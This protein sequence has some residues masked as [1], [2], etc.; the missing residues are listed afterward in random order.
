MEATVPFNLPELWQTSSQEVNQLRLKILAAAQKASVKAILSMKNF[1]TKLL[2]KQATIAETLLSQEWISVQE[3][4]AP[5]VQHAGLLVHFIRTHTEAFARAVIK[6]HSLKEF[7]F[8]VNAV[9]P[10]M[11]AWFHCDESLSPAALFYTIVLANA[12]PK[13]A[14]RIISPFFQALPTFR[15]IEAVME[16]FTVRLGSEVVLDSDTK[17]TARLRECARA[18]IQLIAD[19]IALLPRAHL[20]LLNLM[21]T[22]AWA[23]KQIKNAFLKYFFVPLARQWVSASP[24]SDYLRLFDSILNV[25]FAEDGFEAIYGRFTYSPLF[26][27]PSLYRCFDQ[28]FVLHLVTAAEAIMAVDLLRTQMEIPYSLETTAYLK[29]PASFRFSPFLVKAFPPEVQVPMVRPIR[30]IYRDIQIQDPPSNTEFERIYRLID[31]CRSSGTVYSTLSESRFQSAREIPGFETFALLKSTSDLFDKCRKFENFLGYRVQMRRVQNWCRLSDRSATIAFLTTPSKGALYMLAP[32]SLRRSRF[33]LCHDPT[34]QAVRERYDQPLKRLEFFWGR[35]EN[36][37]R[38]VCSL[39]QT[40]LP[41]AKQRLFWHA[42]EELHCLAN[43]RLYQQFEILA[44]VLAKVRLLGESM[45]LVIDVAVL[46]Q[47]GVFASSFLILSAHV[48]KNVEFA[49]YIADW[50]HEMW[51]RCEKIL[52]R[53]I[54]DPQR[55]CK[56]LR[57]AFFDIQARIG[58]SL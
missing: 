47:S 10:C 5:V 21:R 53:T 32:N 4:T 16:P 22:A 37:M 17:N 38:A 35:L 57:A 18:L 26:E 36:E 25:A 7:E 34:L 29:L 13:V 14:I 31:K 54:T 11:F 43:A 12:Q 19:G 33:L 39:S 52:I 27:V 20:T 45:D 1:P 23:K 51:A 41:L 15:F 2:P 24:W 55:R 40:K 30:V 46:S 49:G 44:G 58:D 8:V 42:V 48:V 6:A 9:V 50:E 56:E 3:A 28:T